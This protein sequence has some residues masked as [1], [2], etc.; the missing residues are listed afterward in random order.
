[1]ISRN[2]SPHKLPICDSNYWFDEAL[3]W[4]KRNIPSRDEKTPPKREALVNFE[5]P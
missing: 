2:S 1:M 5:C 4:G 3:D